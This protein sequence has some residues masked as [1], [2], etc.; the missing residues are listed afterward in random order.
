MAEVITL[1][2]YDGVVS[3]NKLVIYNFN[4][5]EYGRTKAMVEL[6][7]HLSNK[8]KLVFHVVF[9][10]NDNHKYTKFTDANSEVENVRLIKIDLPTAVRDTHEIYAGEMIRYI[11][12]LIFEADYRWPDVV[13]ID[14]A[15]QIVGT[16]VVNKLLKLAIDTKIDI[17]TATRLKSKNYTEGNV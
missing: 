10:V 6:T 9:D 8:D 14:S 17:Y 1:Q 5:T 7:G 15:D 2:S 4:R 13:V 3:D 12:E 16:N 11:E